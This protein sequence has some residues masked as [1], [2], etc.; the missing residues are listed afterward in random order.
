MKTLF[1]LLLTA[2]CL[3]ITTPIWAQ[4]SLLK[5]ANELYE[6]FSYPKAIEVYQK[7][8]EKDKDNAEAMEKLAH[9]HRLTSNSRKAEFWYKK[10][11]KTNKKKH[12]LTL[13]Y[14]Q[15]LMSNRKYDEAKSAFETYTNLVPHDK[16]G[17][18]FLEYSRNI[19]DYMRDSSMFRVNKLPV[20]SMESDFG[21][22][23]FRDG[24]VFTSARP[25]GGFLERK[26]EWTGET[27]VDIYFTKENAGK[28]SEP[29]KLNGKPN[30]SYD[31]G[32]AVFNAQNTLMYFTRN[33]VKGKTGKGNV[34]RLGIFVA[35]WVG[36]EWTDIEPMP[37]NSENYSVGHPALSTDGKKLYFTSD[38]PNGTG[39]KDIYISEFKNGRWTKPE[40][41]GESVNTEGDEMF[42]FVH[43]DGTLYFA[44]NGWGGFGGLDIFAAK[45]I[46]EDWAVQ[47]VGYPVN[48]PQDDF[49]LILNKQKTDG[50]ISSNRGGK[51]DD[52]YKISIQPAKANQ[53]LVQNKA[54]VL[55]TL[56]PTNQQTEVENA[57]YTPAI[58]K[59]ALL[60]KA[61][62]PTP[63]ITP[64]QNTL[65]K[66]PNEPV[67]ASKT[68][69]KPIAPALRTSVDNTTVAD[70]PY[71]FVP[72]A[73]NKKITTPKPMPEKE[74][75]LIGI[76]I[77]KITKQPLE[78]A[79]VVLENIGS[80][81]TPQQFV[82]EK[83]GNFWFKLDKNK[84]YALKKLL[85]ENAE[86][87][88]LIS[89]LQPEQTELVHAILEG[90]MSKPTY[91]GSPAPN[92]NLNNGGITYEN[93][94]EVAEEIAT[95]HTDIPAPKDID[96]LTF[97]V[98]IGSFK[99]AKKLAAPYFKKVRPE[100]L[101][102]KLYTEYRGGLYRYVLGEY[103][104][105]HNAESIRQDLIN[106]GYGDAYVA[107]Y[108]NGY[109]I[110]KPIEDILSEY[111]IR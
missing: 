24:I 52:I 32:P 102:G 25:Q 51:G 74:V 82:T 62:P 85:G 61:E 60:D 42:P 70:Q 91:K 98:Q 80:G 111:N 106:R 48:G 97:R 47:N 68:S 73:N 11:I 87:V 93:E 40:N 65:P 38:M 27:V 84:Q 23:F 72:S 33:T 88:K 71:M 56:A 20:S 53:M 14:A 83:N 107:G 1:S 44:S 76:V 16:R 50:F 17:W 12:I 46:E 43:D 39:G 96:G 7:I 79:T 29:E 100:V 89:T 26:S 19:N 66:L 41:M 92:N 108:I 28:W 34:A 5:E 13:Y 18:N 103:K 63:K 59:V 45:P 104:T 35:R 90:G 49:G 75:V 6:Q 37:F 3:A 58:S 95:K 86:D 64:P 57:A 94:K 78:N 77:N 31:E 8:L 30:S 2:A 69:A 4:N 110:E 67:M 109:R 36:G 99:E 21:A 81:D 22:A 55:Q 54:L 9:C 105:Y 101:N 15:A 10:A